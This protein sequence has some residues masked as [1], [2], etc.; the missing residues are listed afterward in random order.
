MFYAYE[1]GTSW[2]IFNR[3][4]EHV[5]IHIKVRK[6]RKG[7]R[8]WAPIANS[9]SQSIKKGKKGS[10]IEKRKGLAKKKCEPIAS[11][12]HH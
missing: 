9:F 5:N 1:G 4:K 3:D 11:Q 2:N 7:A 12:T 8:K 6:K 10:L